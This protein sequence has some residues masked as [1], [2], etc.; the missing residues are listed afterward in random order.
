[1]IAAARTRPNET[2]AFALAPLEDPVADGDALLPDLLPL[3]EVCEP[4][5][6]ADTDALVAEADPD[7]AALLGDADPVAP[8][9]GAVD[10]PSICACT[11]ELN[12]PVM[13]VRLHTCIR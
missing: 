4:V 1:M 2:T 5:T 7:A 12:V 11:L 6:D 3:A 9:T 13:P 10:A 8:T